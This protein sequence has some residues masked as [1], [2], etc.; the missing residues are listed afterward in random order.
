VPRIKYR[1]AM[2]NKKP[3][4]LKPCTKCGNMTYLL[5]D[6]RW[7]DTKEILATPHLANMKP[8]C[9]PCCEDENR[10][11]RKAGIII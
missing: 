11:Q 5:R 8:M 4:E 10:A 9:V 6:I 7:L 3:A 1:E 2:K